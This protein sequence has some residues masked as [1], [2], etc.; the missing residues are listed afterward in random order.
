MNRKILQ[1]CIDALNQPEVDVSYI[2]GILETL[3]ESLPEE[4]NN[5]ITTGF[6]AKNTIPEITDDAKALDYMAK[7]KIEETKRMAGE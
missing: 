1:K 5:D 7:A 6:V 3:I 2:R 4:K